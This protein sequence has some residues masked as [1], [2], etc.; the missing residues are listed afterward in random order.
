VARCCTQK[1]FN[2]FYSLLRTSRENWEA[3]G[4]PPKPKGGGGGS[5]AKN[6][7][8]KDTGPSERYKREVA[9]LFQNEEL[10]HKFME[11][12]L[13][14]CNLVYIPAPDF[15]K[16]NR[17]MLATTHPATVR[18]P[19]FRRITKKEY[20]DWIRLDKKTTNGYIDTTCTTMRDWPGLDAGLRSLFLSDLV[21]GTFARLLNA[22]NTRQ[23][24]SAAGAAGPS[25]AAGP[26]AAAADTP[27]GAAG[28][29]AGAAGTSAA[30]AGTSAAAAGTSAAA[31]VGT[32]AAAAGATE[33]AGTSAAATAAKTSAAA[34]GSEGG[35]EGLRVVDFGL[36]GA[37]EEEEEDEDEESLVSSQEGS[38]A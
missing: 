31:A 33:A 34:E 28:T 23:R 20:E 4:C 11:N 17:F 22:A 19:G 24:D 9:V 14:A 37:D 10:A 15:Y 5:K 1:P 27:S 26:S 21:D 2:G 30:A 7:T 8:P 25:D 16:L 29:P 36:L 35:S 32:S 18:L 38:D 13:A 12:K 3:L 6:A